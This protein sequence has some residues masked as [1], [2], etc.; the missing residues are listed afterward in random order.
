MGPHEFLVILWTLEP[1]RTL[2]EYKRPEPGDRR[3]AKLC[4]VIGSDLGFEQNLAQD[5]AQIEQIGSNRP[6]SAQ[7]DQ[8]SSDWSKSGQSGVNLAN[9]KQIWPIWRKYGQSEANLANLKQIWPI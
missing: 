3:G 5:P 6:N 7:I 9:L 8:S 1:P 2:L 4:V